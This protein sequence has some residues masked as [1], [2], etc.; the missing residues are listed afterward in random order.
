MQIGY[1]KLFVSITIN[2]IMPLGYHTSTSTI[3]NDFVEYFYKSV[4]EFLND[5][6]K[7]RTM[8]SS[9]NFIHTTLLYSLNLDKFEISK[10]INGL[11]GLM[12]NTPIHL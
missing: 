3:K 9:A 2:T 12:L 5:C 11:L 1:S 10:R 8:K 4:K 7:T 6:S